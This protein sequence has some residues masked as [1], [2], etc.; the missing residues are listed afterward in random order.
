MNSDEFIKE[1]L[2]ALPLTKRKEWVLRT[3]IEPDL[4]SLNNDKFFREDRFCKEI[5]RFLLTKLREV[6][7]G[8]DV[9]EHFTE[10][11]RNDRR[12]HS[13]DTHLGHLI[14]KGYIHRRE[15]KDKRTNE[16][17]LNFE[18]LLLLIINT[19]PNIFSSK[20]S[21]CYYCGA[22]SYTAFHNATMKFDEGNVHYTIEVWACPSCGRVP[23]Q[24]DWKKALVAFDF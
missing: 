19:N 8:A 1:Y 7:Y 18:R 6:T 12:L 14:E 9:Q 10:S 21:K 17:I 3:L 24:I 2:E 20:K 5:L 13:L 15:G 4:I 23:F 16:I 22:D 11:R